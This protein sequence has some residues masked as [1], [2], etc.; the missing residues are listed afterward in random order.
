MCHTGRNLGNCLSSQWQPPLSAPTVAL[1]ASTAQATSDHQRCNNSLG[2]PQEQ[3]WDDASVGAHVLRIAS[4][5]LRV[6]TLSAPA[7]RPLAHMGS[8]Q[9]RRYRLR[10][11]SVR[12]DPPESRWERAAECPRNVSSVM[13]R[14]MRGLKCGCRWLLRKRG[15]QIEQV[16]WTRAVH[17]CLES[18]EVGA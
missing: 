7:E 11:P 15:L 18:A 13:E 3:A 9:R 12:G 16:I 5:G 10:K 8:L 17:D 1:A 14:G 4:C 6:R 2:H